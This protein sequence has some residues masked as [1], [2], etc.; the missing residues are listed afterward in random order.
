[1]RINLCLKRL[2]LRIGKQLFLPLYL[3]QFQLGREQ[4]TQSFS[5]LFLRSTHG[6]RLSVVQQEGGDRFSADHKR[7][8]DDH[9]KGECLLL[10]FVPALKNDPLA[11]HQ[12][13]SN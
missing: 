7:Q 13:V 12:R 5:Q 9:G 2:D 10:L 3:T 11:G 1:M 8:N 6:M 4:L